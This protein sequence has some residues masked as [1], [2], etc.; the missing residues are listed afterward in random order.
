MQKPQPIQQPSQLSVPQ[1][2][3]SQPQIQQQPQQQITGNMSPK[4]SPPESSSSSSSLSNN[5]NNPNNQKNDQQQQQRPAQSSSSASD[6]YYYSRLK[7]QVEFYFSPQNLSRDR[8]LRTLMSQYGGATV[9]LGLIATFPKVREIYA[10]HIKQ[11]TSSMPPDLVSMMRTALDGSSVVKITPDG[12]WIS[13]IGTVPPLNPSAI[14]HG[15]RVAATMMFPNM[16]MGVNVGL[17]GQHPHHLQQQQAQAQH[18]QHLQ[19]QQGSQQQNIPPLSQFSMQQQISAASAPPLSSVRTSSPLSS[20]SSGNDDAN[21]NTNSNV[22]ANSGTTGNTGTVATSSSSNSSRTTLIVSNL[23]NDVATE[24]VMSAFT[25]DSVIPKSA[26][27]LS[28][29]TTT[30]GD[31][32]TNAA[33]TENSESSQKTNSKTTWHVTFATEKDA[34]TALN[35]AKDKEINGHAIHAKIMEDGIGEADHKPSQSQQQ[36]SQQQS[37]QQHIPYPQHPNQHQ[38][39]PHQSPNRHVAAVPPPMYQHQQPLQYPS[40]SH[41]VTPTH[42]G[43]P[44]YPYTTAA[45]QPPFQYP[46]GG[47]GRY[48]TTTAPNHL[49][50][51][52]PPPPPPSGHS[53]PHHAM[54]YPP[55]MYPAAAT[56]AGYPY[57]PP[58]T[59]RPYYTTA[60]PP[61]STTTNPNQQPSPQHVY[62]RNVMDGGTAGGAQLV[63][64]NGPMRKTKSDG[65]FTAGGVGAGAGVKSQMRRNNRKKN[66]QNVPYSDNY[67]VG[68]NPFIVQGQVQGQPRMNRGG[69]SREGLDTA[70]SASGVNEFRKGKAKD[71]YGYGYGP[72][73]YQSRR[74]SNSP[75]LDAVDSYEG[76]SVTG[77]GGGSRGRK[78]K[79]KRRGDGTDW[80]RRKEQQQQ[81][82]NKTEIFDEN[83]FPALSP[84]KLKQND[85]SSSATN[86]ASNGF[87][88]YADALRQKNKPKP[89]VLVVDAETN[90]G[91]GG[92]SGA[93]EAQ[94]RTETI[95]EMVAKIK[96]STV[97]DSLVTK[98][99]DSS[100]DS[101][102]FAAKPSPDVVVVVD[103]DINADKP[104]EPTIEVTDNATDLTDL[105]GLVPA[106]GST[107]S[108]PKPISMKDEPTPKEASTINVKPANET[109]KL[110]V[111]PPKQKIVSDEKNYD[112]PKTVVGTE[113]EDNAAST[114]AW[115]SKRSFIDVSQVFIKEY[116]LF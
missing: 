43:I 112:T 93:K 106:S 58:A 95:D 82:Q 66:G 52:H 87:S 104:S 100:E 50:H 102:S 78:K 63:R 91:G 68:T 69:G 11:T 86:N 31:D 61:P 56:T 77:G 57:M 47:G 114:G 113:T 103:D 74:K 30:S 108:P 53:H 55:Q 62:V 3:Q 15:Q 45:Y 111:T 101:T 64:P 22:N 80:D 23:P 98:T 79:S 1:L 39:I 70:A 41:M 6:S 17:G 92:N 65:S 99:M 67:S 94:P 88:G 42:Q 35:A 109:K 19:Q 36:Q 26:K 8:Y 16:A 73:S 84:A 49:Q 18:P 10:S 72:S 110:V 32:N 7:S 116:I 89:V 4:L 9:P 40:V 24:V 97:D 14:S 33:A 107:N 12:V 75:M 48:P 81:Q 60:G 85:T 115:G 5:S 34:T 96:I 83:M 13:P 44:S 105:N 76:R 71:G 37:Q 28:S 25:T 29:T 59:A 38:P 2:Q 51:S 27:P 46:A 54:Q 21:A 90:D 20:G